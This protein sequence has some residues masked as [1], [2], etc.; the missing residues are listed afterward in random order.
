MR[1]FRQS[2]ESPAAVAIGGP[3]IA[4]TLFAT[5]A[6]V[7]I[8]ATLLYSA[9]VCS[10]LYICGSGGGICSGG[11]DGN[12]GHC[13]VWMVSPVSQVEVA[14]TA[15][16]LAICSLQ[17]DLS[18]IPFSF[19]SRSLH[20]TLIFVFWFIKLGHRIQANYQEKVLVSVVDWSIILECNIF[21]YS[22]ETLAKDWMHLTYCGMLRLIGIYIPKFNNIVFLLWYI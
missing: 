14:T 11:C 15:L 6:M 21:R 2:P 5:T 9:V 13:G 17:T 22:N 1:W 3:L 10:R 18:R 19:Q 4:L 20:I 8:T 7:L 12:G 16:G